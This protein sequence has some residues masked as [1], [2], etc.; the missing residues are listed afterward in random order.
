MCAG[1]IWQAAADPLS[2]RVFYDQDDPGPKAR[3]TVLGAGTF[4]RLRAA[5]VAGRP[6][7]IKI[8]LESFVG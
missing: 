5:R 3:L 2:I 6:E 7:W 4:E 1:M 8:G